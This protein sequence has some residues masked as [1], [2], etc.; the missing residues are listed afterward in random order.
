MKLRDK[1][2]RRVRGR[3]AHVIKYCR[4]LEGLTVVSFFL[5]QLSVEI[6]CNTEFPD[7]KLCKL[8]VLLSVISNVCLITCIDI[9]IIRTSFS[10]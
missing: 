8:F 1:K 4:D 3:R 10:L 9:C 2:A 7:L 6:G 5:G